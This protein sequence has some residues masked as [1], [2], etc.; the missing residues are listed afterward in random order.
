M[1]SNSPLVDLRCFTKYVNMPNVVG[2]R[3]TITTKLV[4]E[5]EYCF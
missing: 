3:E 2:L 5:N 4:A 1:I